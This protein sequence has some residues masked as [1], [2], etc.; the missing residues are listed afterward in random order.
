MNCRFPLFLR[1]KLQRDARRALRV[2]SQNELHRI[3]AS[4]SAKSSSILVQKAS[5]KRAALATSSL[6][7]SIS[8]LRAKNTRQFS[9]LAQAS[10]SA[11]QDRS[12]SARTA[13]ARGRLH[14]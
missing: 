5:T 8:F 13:S 14:F 6:A 2:T 7:Q 12:G 9:R 10:R 11:E 4:S 1:S 3:S